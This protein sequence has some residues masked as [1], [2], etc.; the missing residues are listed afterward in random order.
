M[1]QVQQIR[2]HSQDVA[3]SVL[4]YGKNYLLTANTYIAVLCMELTLLIHCFAFPSG[5]GPI[6]MSGNSRRRKGK[7]QGGRE[8]DFGLIV[9]LYHPN[10]CAA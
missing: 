4:C 3:D 9:I 1:P 8:G 10:C 6:I 2:T 7:R 5:Q